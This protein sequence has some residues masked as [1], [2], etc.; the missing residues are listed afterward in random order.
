MNI[1]EHL[2]HLRQVH[3]A[4][5]RQM[6]RAHLIMV[7][8]VFAGGMLTGFGLRGLIHMIWGF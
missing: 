4:E 1:D 3:D 2:K 5:R 8:G 7:L 6:Q